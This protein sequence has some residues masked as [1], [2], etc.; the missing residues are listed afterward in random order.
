MYGKKDAAVS[1]MVDLSSV[2]VTTIRGPQGA[3]MK[4]ALERGFNPSGIAE[5]GKHYGLSVGLR[6]DKIPVV[7]EPDG[8]I[9]RYNI[10]FYSDYTLIRSADGTELKKGVL[11]R[12]VSYNAIESDF[13]TYVSEQDIIHRGLD[14]LSEDYR[15]ML[16]AFFQQLQRRPAP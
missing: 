8:S 6:Y 2:A 15:L 16:A 12:T 5:P 11:K 4:A 10:N 13:A 1:P 9:N 14:D 7:I 3:Q